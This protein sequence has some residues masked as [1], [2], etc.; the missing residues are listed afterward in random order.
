MLSKNRLNAP[1]VLEAHRQEKNIEKKIKAN[2]INTLTSDSLTKTP[3]GS[4]EPM[5]MAIRITATIPKLV[6][7]INLHKIAHE[8]P[9]NFN[10]ARSL[11][12]Y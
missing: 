11:I 7:N 3:S 8:K 5:L 1:E 6:S 9:N 12:V 2:E 4:T 10:I